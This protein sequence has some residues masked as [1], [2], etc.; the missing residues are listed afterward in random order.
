M[1]I[2]IGLEGEG[3]AVE[4][5]V[6][7]V[8]LGNVVIDAAAVAKHDAVVVHLVGGQLEQQHIFVGVVN[9]HVLN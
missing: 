4:A 2:L 5:A 8:L 1:S 9:D 7:E 6:V 3:E